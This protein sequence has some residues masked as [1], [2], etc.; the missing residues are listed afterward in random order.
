LLGA[1]TALD[2]V[3]LAQD[4]IDSLE[5]LAPVAYARAS[6]VAHV[7][8][9][10]LARGP[11]LLDDA[12]LLAHALLDAEAWRAD[13]VYRDL[14]EEIARTTMARL[15]DR[16]G[17]L[18][19]RVAALAGAGQVGRLADA[20]HPLTGNAEAARLLRRLFGDDPVWCAH[21][22][23]ILR[24]VTSDAA[25]AGPFGAPVGLAWHACG[26]AGSVTAAW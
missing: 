15:Q 17:A 22:R 11:M 9:D 25:L 5:V 18:G 7:L 8:E 4:A 26:E 21:A 12:M 20:H 13:G 1:A 10:G 6:G 14:A 19:D 2:R 23:Q 16:S 3:D 24:A